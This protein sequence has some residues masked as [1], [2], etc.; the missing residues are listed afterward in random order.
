MTKRALEPPTTFEHSLLFTSRGR[1]LRECIWTSHEPMVGY[2]VKEPIP[3]EYKD[4]FSPKL[5]IEYRRTCNNPHLSP[6]QKVTF[7][8]G[9]PDMSD[10]KGEPFRRAWGSNDPQTWRFLSNKTFDGFQ[11]GLCQELSLDHNT[12]QIS[13]AYW[14]RKKV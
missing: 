10:F 11:L 4:G 5:K 13:I 2:H 9:W 12:N 6:D 7:L 3:L 1:I 14:I 8:H